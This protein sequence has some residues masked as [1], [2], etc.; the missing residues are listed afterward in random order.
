M[1]KILKR[2]SDNIDKYVKCE[3][4]ITEILKKTKEMFLL[5]SLILTTV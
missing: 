4:H 1:K 5:A 3:P 2:N